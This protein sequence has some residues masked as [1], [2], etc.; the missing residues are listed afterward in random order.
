MEQV[1]EEENAEEAHYHDGDRYLTPAS[2]VVKS[3]QYNYV[4]HEDASSINCVS[5]HPE[6]N[7]LSGESLLLLDLI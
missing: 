4:G 7:I 6:A 5:Q 2:V 1:F 3:M